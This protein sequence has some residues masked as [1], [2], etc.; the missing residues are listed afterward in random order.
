MF[1]IEQGVRGLW[2]VTDPDVPGLFAAA[3]Y[4]DF[5]L[6]VATYATPIVRAGDK[7]HPVAGHSL[8]YDP[9]T[10]VH[11]LIPVPDWQTDAQRHETVAR[12]KAFVDALRQRILGE[13]PDARSS[14]H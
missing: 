12:L 10:S 2:Y 1:N 6:D 5:A 9:L 3:V 8:W 4:R 14:H 13:E 7:D 11:V